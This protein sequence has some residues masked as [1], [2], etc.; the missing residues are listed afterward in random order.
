MINYCTKIY[1][2]ISDYSMDELKGL[3]FKRENK[4]Y[5]KHT[6]RLWII[7]FNSLRFF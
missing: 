7:F 1:H 6:N 3:V 5:D 2:W 4:N